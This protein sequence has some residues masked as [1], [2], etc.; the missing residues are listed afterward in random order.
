MSPAPE[1]VNYNAPVYPE[2]AGQEVLSRL[3]NL[4]GDPK[5]AEAPR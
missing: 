3:T 1:E 2:T 5:Y 4:A